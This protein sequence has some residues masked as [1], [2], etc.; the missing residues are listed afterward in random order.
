MKAITLHQPWATLV[1]IEQ[2]KI[3]TRSWPTSYRGPLAIHAAKT[4]PD[5]KEAWINLN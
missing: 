3:E 4:M 5:Y 2:K 1:A